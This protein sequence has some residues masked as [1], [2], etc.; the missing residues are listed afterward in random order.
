MTQDST[1]HPGN[2]EERR[3]GFLKEAASG[4]DSGYLKQEGL[5]P[6]TLLGTES[7]LLQ[8]S[9]VDD[10]ARAVVVEGN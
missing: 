4:L 8:N 6:T 10:V 7:C 3:E 5:M 2:P 9:Y 1:G